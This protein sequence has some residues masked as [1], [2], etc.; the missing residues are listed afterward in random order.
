MFSTNLYNAMSELKK[1]IVDRYLY[2]TGYLIDIYTLVVQQKFAKLEEWQGQQIETIT[3][4]I[5]TMAV[6]EAVERAE[7]PIIAVR[8]LLLKKDYAQL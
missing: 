2:L 5:K 1:R 8:T 4:E 6:E 7:G 3:E